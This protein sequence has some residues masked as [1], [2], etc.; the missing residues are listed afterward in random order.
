MLSFS[1]DDVAYA[2]NYHFKRVATLRQHLLKNSEL[3]ILN[4]EA[5]RKLPRPRVAQLRTL[6]MVLRPQTRDRQPLQQQLQF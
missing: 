1:G 3:Y 5:L 6:A 4:F 2:V